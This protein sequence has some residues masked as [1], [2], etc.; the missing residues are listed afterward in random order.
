[1]RFG[2]ILRSLAALTLMSGLGLSATAIAAPAVLQT[3]DP[4]SRVNI[5]SAPTTQAN[6]QHYGVSGDRIET[7]RQAPG[8]GGYMWHYVRFNRS[9]AEGWVRGDLLRFITHDANAEIVSGTYW[10]APTGQGL[11]IEGDRYYYYHEEG[12]E[13]WRP[14]SELEPVQRGVVFDG[15]N[16]WCLS[17]LPTPRQG[18][19]VCSADGWVRPNARR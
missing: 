6:I 13:P 10:L 18:I 9:G 8:E 5:R 14:V 19:A 2:L 3:T 4:E 11:K 16:Y 1:M 7:L 17:T 15:V 12:R